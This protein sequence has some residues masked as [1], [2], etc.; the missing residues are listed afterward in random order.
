MATYCERPCYYDKRLS[1]PSAF[2]LL[3]ILLLLLPFPL[4]LVPD[5]ATDILLLC[6]C[7]CLTLV[8]CSFLFSFCCRWCQLQQRS[9]PRP[10]P[11]YSPSCSFSPCYMY[12]PAL[13]CTLFLPAHD[14]NITS[15]PTR[16][17]TRGQM[18]STD[19][20]MDDEARKSNAG[21]D[22]RVEV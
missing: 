10:S 14:K 15:K 21:V 1:M 6:S 13:K 4:P 20:D 7:P 22:P 11:W 5:L 12:I 18:S 8:G 19:A 16:L 3:R 9:P 17:H 2:L